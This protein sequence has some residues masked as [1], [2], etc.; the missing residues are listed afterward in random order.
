MFQSGGGGKRGEGERETD[1]QT[2]RQTDAQKD[3]TERQVGR[4]TQTGRHR[5]RQTERQEKKDI[6]LHRKSE[7]EEEAVTHRRTEAQ[8]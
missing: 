3:E 2:D 5:D 7:T 8:T 1:R 6:D 4:L